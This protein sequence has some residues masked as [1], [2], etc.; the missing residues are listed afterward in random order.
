M[1]TRCVKVINGKCPEYN[2][3]LVHPTY[4]ELLEYIVAKEEQGHN[5]YCAI[6]AHNTGSL[7]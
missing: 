3:E 7:V 4:V 2:T 6:Y 1:K 5:G